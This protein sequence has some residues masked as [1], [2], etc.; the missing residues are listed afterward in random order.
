M[1][2]SNRIGTPI[3]AMALAA[4]SVLSVPSYAQR[5]GRG[6]PTMPIVIPPPEDPDETAYKT[7]NSTQETEKKITL[8]LQFIQ[9]YPKSQYVGV[10]YRTLVNIF[11][12]KQDWGDFYATADDAIAK[13][14]D[15]VDV[16]TVVGWVIP[17]FFQENDPSAKK[18]LDQAVSYEKHAI[19]LIQTIPKPPD[20]TD[21]QFAA[22]KV[23]KL[24]RAHSGLGLVY[25][26]T[27]DYENCVKE[28]QQATQTM[29][30][31]D[32]TDL[33]AL[34]YALQQLNRYNEAV[35]TFQKCSLMPSLLQ[36]RCQMYAD[37]AK[38]QALQ[39]K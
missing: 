20:T 34:G 32:P 11:Y 37:Q 8:G 24:A 17:H 21:E 26:R 6:T 5:G 3:L 9:K 36:M 16:L 31:P 1:L 28:L 25:Y 39:V 13:D 27:E 14:P 2:Q 33:Y 7:F 15:D 12:A 4:V 22:L 10:V 18:K 19:E 29:K 23:E 35:D 30:S 38:G